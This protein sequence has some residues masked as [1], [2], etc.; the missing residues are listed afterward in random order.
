MSNVELWSDFDGTAVEIVRKTDPRN[1]SKYP[2]PGLAGYNDFLGGV[3][4]T[5]VPVAGVISR[6][7]NILIRRMAT[8]RSITK[9]GFAELPNR[10]GQIVHT[11]SEEKKGQ[12]IAERSREAV[13]GMLEDRPHR[14]GAILLGAM[15]EPMRHPKV[16]HHSI[17]VGVV[18]HPRSQEYIDRLLELAEPLAGVGLDTREFVD[19]SELG[20][21]T[22]FSFQT[23]SLGLQVV[24]LHP[25]SRQAGE[26]FGNKLLDV[27]A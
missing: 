1:W 17:L 27:A 13:I 24:P 22:G 16:H 10:P 12:F 11:G 8:A 5:G 19:Q 7:P 20:A 21:T 15:A 2:L 25:Y 6:R 9:L 18:A 4:S 23:E 26:V 3:R 14:L